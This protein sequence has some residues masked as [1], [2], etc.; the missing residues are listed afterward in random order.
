MNKAWVLHKQRTI[1][2]GPRNGKI[3]TLQSGI[4]FRTLLSFCCPPGSPGATHLKTAAPRSE[5]IRRGGCKPALS[6][7]GVIHTT[8]LPFE[9]WHTQ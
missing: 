8:G 3:H 5:L 1:H 6:A 7:Y 9:F 2:R 4:G